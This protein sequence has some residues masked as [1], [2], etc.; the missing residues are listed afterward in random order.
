MSDFHSWLMAEASFKHSLIQVL[1]SQPLLYTSSTLCTMY[2]A[3]IVPF[4]P[5]ALSP[6]YRFGSQGHSAPEP[7]FESRSVGHPNRMFLPQHHLR[8]ILIIMLKSQCVLF[9]LR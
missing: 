3:H 1:A 9:N 4:N 5:F 2:V 6:F 8:L 7:G